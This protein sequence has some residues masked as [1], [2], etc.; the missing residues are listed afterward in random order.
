MAR[1]NKPKKKLSIETKKKNTLNPGIVVLALSI[2]FFVGLYYLHTHPGIFQMPSHD[3]PRYLHVINGYSQEKRVFDM[4]EDQTIMEIGALGKVQ[5]LI[6]EGK[7]CIEESSCPNQTCVK[8]GWIAAI[9]ESVICAPNQVMI[10]IQSST[11]SIV[12]EFYS[13]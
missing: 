11:E 12:P 5:I 1:R 8:S 4:N 7:A 3:T 10:R 13:E 6:R 2:L 9:G